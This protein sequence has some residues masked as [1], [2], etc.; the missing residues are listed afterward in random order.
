MKK[1]AFLLV[2]TV[3]VAQGCDDSTEPLPWYPPLEA[4]YELIEI[5]GK[6]LPVLIG[7]TGDGWS[8]TVNGGGVMCTLPPINSTFEFYV[9]TVTTPTGSTSDHTLEFEIDCDLEYPAEIRYTY[10]VTGD[11]IVGEILSGGSRG[12]AFQRKR[13]PRAV[14]LSAALVAS[15]TILPMEN[16]FPYPMP[17]GIFLTNQ[18]EG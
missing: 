18:N 17:I 7:E 5:D 6:R 15:G 2:G 3:L 16:P 9:F 14:V 8:L 11:T 1:A 4:A 13:L 10:P 12:V